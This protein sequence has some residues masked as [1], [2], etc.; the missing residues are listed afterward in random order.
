M[1]RNTL[2]FGIDLGTTNSVVA[3]L[4]GM[5]RR[6]VKNQLGQECT[7]SVVW[8]DKKQ[9]IITGQKAKERQESNESNNIAYE[10]KQHMGK[11]WQFSFS[12]SGNSMRPDDLS[13]EIL[14]TLRESAELNSKDPFRGAVITV[15]ADFEVPQNNM[16]MK[17]AEIAGFEYFPLLQEP[18]AAALAYGYESEQDNVYWLVYDLG[19]GTF[20]TALINMRDG[21]FNVVNHLGDNRLG[22]QKIDWL[23]VEELL[24]PAVQKTFNLSNIYVGNDDCSGLI[25]TLK[26]A[27]EKAKISLSGSLDSIDIEIPILRGVNNELYQDFEFELKSSDVE[28]FADPIIDRTLRKCKQML[29]DKRLGAANIEKILLVGGPTQMPYL[30]ERLADTKDGLGI[31]LEFNKDPL[32]VVAEGAAIFA[33]TQ[34]VESSEAFTATNSTIKLQVEYEASGS[35]TEPPVAGKIVGEPKD[36]YKNYTVEFVNTSSQPEWRSGKIGLS[37]DGSFSADLWAEKG[38]ENVFKIELYNDKA[39]RVATSPESISYR[40]GVSFAEI[41]LTHSIGVALVTNEVIWFANKGEPLPV[42]QRNILR[43]AKNLHRGDTQVL[44]VSIVEGESE[45]ADRNQLLGSLEINSDGNDRDLPIGSELEILV[46]V[47][48]SRVLTAQV[49]IPIL[50]KEYEVVFDYSTYGNN[51]SFEKLSA[52]FNDQKERLAT[53]ESAVNESNHNASKALQKIYSNRMVQEVEEYLKSAER[54]VDSVERCH[55]RL[56]ELMMTLDEV[57]DFLLWPSLVEEAQKE[58]KAERDIINNEI[59]E[60]TNEEK[61]MVEHLTKQIDKAIHDE[62]EELLRKSIG[63]LDRI[64]MMIVMR[65]DGWWMAQFEQIKE[66]QDILEEPESAQ[67][68]ISQSQRAIQEGNSESLRSSVRQLW[69]MLPNDDP[70]RMKYSDVMR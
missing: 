15:P 67:N 59:W 10:F 36:E 14:K 60:A 24:I 48:E 58:I 18:V 11:D 46:K 2:D 22:G 27:A 50:D 3:K 26:N 54:N 6:I 70:D 30:R 33:G 65:H 57:E 17:A 7:P 16:T 23:I 41:P 53:Y 31:S 47:S 68:W 37:P 38:C 62:N 52:E 21:M 42:R 69:A 12:N 45:R 40:V 51:S 43:T 5:D 64:G 4:E 44:R 35:D 56:R 19:G 49:Y 25:A 55:T 8:V 63:E 66:K 28:R 9:R 61:E 29:E 32:T 34:R 13:A 20:D 1:S 39:T